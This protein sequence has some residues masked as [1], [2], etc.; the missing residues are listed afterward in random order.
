MPN[1][2]KQQKTLKTRKVN[3]FRLLANPLGSKTLFSGAFFRQ[4]YQHLATTFYLIGF[5]RHL[6]LQKNS[7][8]NQTIT[9]FAPK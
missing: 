1:P 2:K 5:I 3:N 8:K 6:T 9:N 4:Q 7:L